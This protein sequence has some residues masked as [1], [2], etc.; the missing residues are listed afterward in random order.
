M[1][2][3]LMIKGN[4]YLLLASLLLAGS[5]QSQIKFQT[6]APGE[7]QAG[8]TTV[9]TPHLVVTPAAENNRH[10]LLVMIPGTGG[11]ATGLRTFDS[12]FAAMGY[13]VVSL[14]YVNNVIT[15]VCSKSEDSACFDHFRQEIMFGTDVSDKVVV[16]SANSLVNRLTKLLLYQAANDKAWAGF[17]RKGKVRWDKVI[18]A[19]HSQGAGH[20][21]YFGKQFPLRGVLMFSGPQDYLQN[22]NAPA[23]WQRERS[24]T[25]VK[26]YYAFL[27]N[28]DPFNYQYQVADVS[29]INHQAVT[30]TTM[31]QPGQAVHSTRSILVTDIDRKDR[32]GS[33][34]LTDFV[35]VWKYMISNATK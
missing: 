18:A 3:L 22:F 15:T 12:T 8:L 34:L 28:A 32:H 2:L 29:V 27:H 33:T 13:Y 21:A 26:R 5:A 20:A 1:I 16:D 24:R 31:V 7:T 10:Q 9:H 14:D 17:V 35:G 6:V 25:P 4:V 23:H 11:S 30:D 19:G